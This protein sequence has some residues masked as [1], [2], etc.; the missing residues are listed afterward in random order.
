MSPWGRFRG[1]RRR[2]KPAPEPKHGITARSRRGAIGETWWSS[3]FLDVLE[4][5][6]IGT[7]LQRGRSYARGGRVLELNIEPGIVSARVQGSVRVPYD[8]GIR[9]PTLK[10][11]DWARVEQSLAGQAL[12]AARL[13]AGEMP[14]EI[15]HAFKDLGL[16]LFPA[17]RRELHTDCSCPDPANP[18]K[19]IAATFYILAE[20]FDDDP[21]L[22]FAWRGRARETLVANLRTLRGGAA[23]E[24]EHEDAHVTASEDP[25]ALPLLVDDFWRTPPSFPGMH[26]MPT[27][28]EAPDALLRQLGPPPP[29]I[30][31]PELLENLS[32]LYRAMT[33]G[34]EKIAYQHPGT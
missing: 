11:Q 31:G 21:F 8:V 28:S 10:A 25:P 18:C 3:R 22:I 33:A 7:R 27:A 20:A 26:V 4:S 24:P 14:H 6:A 15:E 1:R 17:T 2:R 30:G 5:F 13:L 23:G 12:F 29:E 34:A 32:S 16:S 19:H 9:V